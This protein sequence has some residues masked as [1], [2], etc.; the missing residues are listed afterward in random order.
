MLKRISEEQAREL[1]EHLRWPYGTVCPHCETCDPKRITKLKGTSTRAGVYKCK[2]CR[3][4]FTVTVKTV[5]ERSKVPL[6]NWV[7]VFAAMC[8][9]KKGISAHQ[10]SRELGVQYKTAWFMSHRVRLAMR[11]EAMGKLM[12]TVTVDETYVG[13]RP[14]NPGWIREKMPV[15]SIVE[16]GGRARSMAIPAVRIDRVRD[17]VL[18][19]VD[20]SST[21]MSD[22][23]SLYTNIGA[24]FAAHK[25]VNHGSREYVG[26]NGE[27]SN[28]VE[29]YFANLKRGVHGN[30]HNVSAQH[31]QRFVDEFDFRWSHRHITDSERT[32]QA[33][34][35][36][37]G[38]RLLYRKSSNQFRLITSSGIAGHG[39]Q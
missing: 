12:G 32:L 18:K 13:G 33:L 11:T 30:F 31:L 36:V 21:L 1:L 4:P 38:K 10:L 22:E 19:H 27:T 17:F 24:H 23:H 14:R 9:S 15:I 20:R 26:P 25:T 16:K 3:R 6:R 8:A 37:G 28:E 35:Q 39:A 29:S 34:S 5:M 2:N 7:Y